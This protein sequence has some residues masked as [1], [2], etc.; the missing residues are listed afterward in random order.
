MSWGKVLG[1][2]IVL[3]LG[4]GA[5]WALTR[6]PQGLQYEVQPLYKLPEGV[7]P[8]DLGLVEPGAVAAVKTVYGDFQLSEAYSDSGAIYLVERRE[9]F[10]P[11]AFELIPKEA[12]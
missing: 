7:Q 4:A 3:G 12:T 8:M 1:G 11:V 10:D 6:K 2:A 5:V 9:G